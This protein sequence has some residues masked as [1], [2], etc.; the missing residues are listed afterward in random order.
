MTVPVLFASNCTLLNG[1]VINATD[2]LSLKPVMQTTI[3]RD[4]AGVVF[5]AVVKVFIATFCLIANS[6]TIY[7]VRTRRNLRRVSN[8]FVVNLA[9]SDILVGL[10]MVVYMIQFF[11]SNV[12]RGRTNKYVCIVFHMISCIPPMISLTSVFLITVDRYTA[13]LNPLRYRAIM[14]PFRSAVA[15]AVTWVVMTFI[16]SIMFFYNAWTGVC[17]WFKLI[18]RN[19]FYGYCAVY[20]GIILV[21]ICLNVRIVS[22]A[23]RH[24]KPPDCLDS[25]RFSKGH[26]RIAKSL[27]LLLGC[28]VICWVPAIVMCL[29]LIDDHMFV[30][31]RSSGFR[32]VF[33]IAGHAAVMNS[34]VNPVIYAWRQRD[35]RTSLRALLPSWW[36]CCH[37]KE[38]GRLS[39]LSLASRTAHL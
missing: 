26:R 36:P 30:Y 32:T 15:L 4:F 29:Y 28:F 35:I 25:Q 21:V 19:L 24:V 12:G 31:V 1:S 10:G 16:S 17:I 38:E 6:L 8:R 18:P 11:T 33:D 13:I 9:V 7:V 23:L 22:Q 3:P 2:P 37:N 34:C 27:L 14:T 39:D 20:F 5:F